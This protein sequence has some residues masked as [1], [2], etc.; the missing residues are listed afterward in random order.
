LVSSRPKQRNELMSTGSRDYSMWSTPIKTT[1]KAM[2]HY[3]NSP[4][5]EQWHHS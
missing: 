4:C 1:F 3:S 2:Y 5:V